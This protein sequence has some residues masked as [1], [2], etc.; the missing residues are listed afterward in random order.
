VYKLLTPFQNQLLSFQHKAAVEYTKSD[1][2]HKRLGVLE[3]HSLL[4]LNE[5]NQLEVKAL[6]EAVNA[7]LIG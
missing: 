4:D 7:N 2:D 3:A 5:K 1:H 6:L